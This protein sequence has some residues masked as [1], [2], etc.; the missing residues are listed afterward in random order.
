MIGIADLRLEMAPVLGLALGCF[1]RHKDNGLT[2]AGRWV[3][4]A[5]FIVWLLALMIDF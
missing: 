3:L 4:A 1:L 5:T 2:K